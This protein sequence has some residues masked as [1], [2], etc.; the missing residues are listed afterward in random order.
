MREIPELDVSSRADL[1][2]Y[3]ARVLRRDFDGAAPNLHLKTY[4]LDV[5]TEN[6]EADGAFE[7]LERMARHQNGRVMRTE[8]AT[9]FVLMAQARRKDADGE[10]QPFL[11]DTFDKRFWLAH[12]SG[13]TA[14]V[15]D[16]QGQL[17]REP[18]LDRAWLTPTMLYRAPCPTWGRT[19][20]VLDFS[21]RKLLDDTPKQYASVES[22]EE[23]IAQEIE[24]EHVLDEDGDLAER[25]GDQFKVDITSDDPLIRVERF[26]GISNGQVAPVMRSS[27]AVA[28]P[29]DDSAEG[30]RARAYANGKFVAT[31]RSPGAFTAF[32]SAWQ[33]TY[34]QTI[35]RLETQFRYAPEG[36]GHP[37]NIKFSAPIPD[38]RRYLG[39]LLSCT[40]PFRLWGV[41]EMAGDDFAR[42]RAIDLHVKTPL[43]LEV[44]TQFMRVYLGHDTCANTI[45]RLYTNI[46]Q[47][48]DWGAII[49]GADPEQP[50]L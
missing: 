23:A 19:G 43:Y 6:G 24:G 13:T 8:D 22:E 26:L 41:P 49:Y 36:G 42:V 45:A 20:I 27:F 7:M 17:L 38:L 44:G 14:D 18:G 32:I 29:G 9:L 46:V 16:I 47:R 39:N 33:K 11:V 15:D 4:L 40:E 2:D 12:S 37:I 30:I 10:E 25:R 31:G 35:E 48:Q 3:F 21:D 1:K 50:L 5:H 28:G 34:A